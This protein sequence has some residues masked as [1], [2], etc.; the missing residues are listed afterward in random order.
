NELYR[1]QYQSM[2]DWAERAVSAAKVLQDRPLLA[3][4]LTMPAL[5][6]AMTGSGER[7]R[8][9][10]AD[11]AALVDSLS[12]DEL[13]RRL[14]AVAWLA[15]AELYLDL[16]AEADA[17][18]ERALRLARAT[19]QAELFLVLYQILGRAWYVRG[20][21][22][23]AAELLDGG[24]EASRLFGHTQALVGNLFNRSA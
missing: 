22:V 8:M 14:D 4:A 24:I 10:R 23:E 17:H 18:A 6:H 7:A 16:Y 15:A 11:A 13:S 3:A 20:K 5:A 2:H 19:G 21:L 12:D 9:H 1:S